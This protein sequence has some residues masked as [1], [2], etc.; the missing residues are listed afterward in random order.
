M[1]RVRLL[2]AL[3]AILVLAVAGGAHAASS[4]VVVSQVFA[5]G[6]NT[7]APYANDFVELFNR[8]STAVDLA[9]YAVQYA[10][11]TSTSWQ[12]T[13][14][15]GTL[16][17][18][19]YY[20]VQLASSAA[21][22]AALPTPDATGTTNLAASGGKVALTSTTASLA[23]GASAGSCSATTGVVD[24][25]GY[26]AAS[27]FEGAGSA[28]ALGATT[29]AVRAGGG[30]VD[31]D[32]S[33][34]DFATGAPAPR[35]TGATAQPCGGSGGGS[36]TGVG[37]DTAVHVTLQSVLA[38]ALERGSLDFGQVVPGSTPPP[39]SEHVTVTSTSAAGYTLS[40]HRGAFAP[41][42]L[43]LALAAAAP[44]GATLGSA[45]AGGALV[46]IPIAPAAD[47]V[48]G[49]TSAASA[50]GGD[51][52]PTSVGFVSALPSLA[53]GAYSATVTF[54]AVGR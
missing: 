21:V 17:P 49:G 37:Q 39:L 1:L 18:G 47:A 4:S 19:R 20:L 43:P 23:C 30:C 28:P 31:T 3:L 46:P 12:A 26:G 42:D 50:S 35:N 27:D 33:S 54:T 52:W 22:G 11:A 45:F 34:A 8:G 44:A 25:I 16:Q 24:L 13:P 53:A 36:G 32:S 29:A 7:G 9:G 10:P 15:A 48:I 14:L 51:V 2:V 6:G 40:V 41:A 38:L 5:G